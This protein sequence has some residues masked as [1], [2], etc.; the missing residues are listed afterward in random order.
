MEPDHA[1]EPHTPVARTALSITGYTFI[2]PRFV[3]LLLTLPALA[4]DFDHVLQTYAAD[5][6]FMGSVLVARGSQVLFS[7][8]YGFANLEWRVPN[9]P[10]TK[11]RIGS[12]TKQFTAA[13]ILLLEERGKLTLDDPVKKYLPDAPAAWDKIKI[14]HLL[15]HTSGVP[16]FTGLPD[17]SKLQALS[18]TL[19]ELVSRFRDEPLDFE[20][21]MVKIFKSAEGSRPYMMGIEDDHNHMRS[22]FG[23][24]YRI[25]QP[26]TPAA[27]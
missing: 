23:L 16:D 8:G 10:T 4:Q 19:D 22:A 26:P 1:M 5:H 6:H 3:L 20:P 15:T 17:Y 18:T 13:A 25:G 9:D 14:F 21:R 2:V 11:F 24:R 27:E 7:K 12:I